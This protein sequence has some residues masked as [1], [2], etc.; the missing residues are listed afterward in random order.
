MSALYASVQGERGTATKCGRKFLS[1][2]IRG[3]DLGIRIEARHDE[4]GRD[5]FA[6]FQT[7]GS[8]GVKPEKF[9]F[10]IQSKEGE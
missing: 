10:E 2:H 7:S 5:T 6:V 4:N 3:W 9:V 1:A 8:N